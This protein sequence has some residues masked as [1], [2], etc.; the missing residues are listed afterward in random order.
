M[1][2]TASDNPQRQMQFLY[3]ETRLVVPWSR[4]RAYGIVINEIDENVFVL[5]LTHR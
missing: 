2:K 4:H 1:L 5:L 3:I